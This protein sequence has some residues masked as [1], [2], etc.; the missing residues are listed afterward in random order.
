MSQMILDNIE[1][2]ALNFVKDGT[3]M[4]VRAPQ[5]AQ[6]CADAIVRARVTVEAEA[7][8]RVIEREKRLA[9]DFGMDYDTWMKIARSLYKITLDFTVISVARGP[10]YEKSWP[11]SSESEAREHIVY[12]INQKKYDHF[13][14]GYNFAYLPEVQEQEDEDARAAG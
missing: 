3:P 7:L 5:W 14:R 9:L 1:M 13:V 10:E 6:A 8:A 11:K 2:E 12:L 4:P